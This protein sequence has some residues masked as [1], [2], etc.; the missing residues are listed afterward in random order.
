MSVCVCV[1]VCV[2]SGIQ[3][4]MCVNH[5]VIYGLYGSTIFFHITLHDF[6]GGGEL[7]NTECV[8]WFYLQLMSETFHVLRRNGRDMVI[9]LHVKYLLFYSDI[10]E[11]WI[12]S[13]HFRKIIMYQISWKSILRESGSSMRTDGRA[14]K[15]QD[16]YDETN[17]CFHNSANAPKKQD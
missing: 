5:M 7:L 8:F 9:G 10:N 15:Q 6:E 13:T 11:T 16:R 4:A 14:G 2:A 3:H 12:F 1:C 17:T